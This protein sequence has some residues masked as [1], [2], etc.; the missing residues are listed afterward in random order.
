[1]YIKQTSVVNS[2]LFMILFLNYAQKQNQLYCNCE[3][4]IQYITQL[5]LHLRLLIKPHKAK[6]NGTSKELRI[7]SQVLTH[8]KGL[9]ASIIN[10]Q[11]YLTARKTIK[12][13]ST[14]CKVNEMLF[15]MDTEKCKTSQSNSIRKNQNK[16]MLKSNCFMSK[17]QY[18]NRLRLAIRFEIACKIYITTIG[19]Q[20][21]ML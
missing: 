14:V 10:H 7:D 8:T 19:Y 18:Q 3:Q 4:S 2:F 6:C 13:A 16:R 1:M 20:K 17:H 5:Q 15:Q 21:H 12:G 9:T 11:W